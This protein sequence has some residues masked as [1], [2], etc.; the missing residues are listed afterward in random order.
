VRT[1]KIA[2]VLFGTPGAGSFIAA[3]E[4]AFARA[5]LRLAAE[6]ETHWLDR[7]EVDWRIGRLRAIAKAGPDLIVLHGAQGEVLVGA[8]AAEFPEVAFS[9]TQGQCAGANV[10]SYEVLLEQP[11]FLAGALAGWCS[12]TG[13][14]G[15]LSGERVRAGLK[16]RAAFAAGLRFAR[17]DARLLST[18]C[19]AQHD[20]LL[21]AQLVMA[22]ARAGAG[23]VFTMLGAGREGAIDAC[24]SSGI[25]QIGDGIDWCAIHPDVFLASV[26]AD[27][28]WASYQAIDDFV[29]GSLCAGG[30]RSIGLG[31]PQVCRLVL[32]A[33]LGM[34]I[35]GRL[36][37]LAEWLL[38]GR[39]EIP[40]IWSGA[41]FDAG[42]LTE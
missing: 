25:R 18:F 5:R 41:E 35:R 15:H 27:A 8:L 33:D 1:A 21:A 20:P 39:V 38:A 19:G 13:V 23:I 34:E 32:G 30:R 28:G 31:D 9:L 26:L 37:D 42:A 36:E 40:E 6:V 22:Q 4:A 17:P 11:A 10:A 24:R 14:V 12:G 2:G 3:G 16:G 7:N 29:V